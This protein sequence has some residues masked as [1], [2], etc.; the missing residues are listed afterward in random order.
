MRYAHALTA[1]AELVRS[2]QH[3]CYAKKTESR[4]RAMDLSLQHRC[5]RGDFEI[6]S[7]RYLHY[8]QRLNLRCRQ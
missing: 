8:F 5:V 6:R 3:C 1:Q 2:N 4:R 7:L